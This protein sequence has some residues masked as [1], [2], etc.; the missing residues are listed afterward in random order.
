VKK[1]VLFGKYEEFCPLD[2][3]FP[4]FHAGSLKIRLFTSFKTLN[5]RF[6]TLPIT[7]KFLHST[8]QRFD[9]ANTKGQQLN[10]KEIN[11]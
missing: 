5:T 7:T 2:I 6:S 9:T 4:K 11:S 10:V 1:Q 3:T 8:V